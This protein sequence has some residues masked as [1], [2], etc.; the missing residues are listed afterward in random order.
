[1]N[2][3]DALISICSLLLATV[4]IAGCW[5]AAPET[6]PDDGTP[7]TDGTP[8]D[9]TPT[10]GGTPATAGL[11]A[12]HDAA[13]AFADIPSSYVSDALN[14]FHIYYGHTSHG[15]QIVTGMDLLADEDNAFAYTGG[16]DAFLEENDGVDLGHEGDLT[17]V[18]ITRDRLNEAGNNINIVM[19]SWC[20]GVSDN[21]EAG[22]NAYLNAMNQLEQDY[23]AITFVY[24]TGHLD[25]T[26]VDGNLNVR[27]EQ[28]RDY[29]SA[30]DKVL[31]DFADIESYDPDGT[32]YP[33]GTDWCEWCQTWCAANTCPD[34]DC[35]DGESCQHSVC[36]NCYRKGQAFWWMMARLAGWDGTGE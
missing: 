25:G 12:D 3:K 28:I 31:F 34:L 17:W 35:A 29:C 9:G 6:T 30:S 16:V 2:R 24:M 27:N 14:T 10:D 18:D 23:P 26:G 33:D 1:M 4:G 36:F 8:A 19:W 11:V 32:V 5:M 13:D 21:T 20:G 7:T 15:G 22:I